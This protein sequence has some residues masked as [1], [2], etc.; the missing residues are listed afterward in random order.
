MTI[1]ITEQ[2]TGFSIERRHLT[3]T[4]ASAYTGDVTVNYPA[5]QR[6]Y[7]GGERVQIATEEEGVFVLT[8]LPPRSRSAGKNDKVFEL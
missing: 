7:F 2:L 4:L 8:P 5:A 3:L 1:E 6:F